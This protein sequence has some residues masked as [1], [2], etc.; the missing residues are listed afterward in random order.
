[1]QKIIVNNISINYVHIGHGKPLVLLHG[2]PLDH[3]IWD[4]L[5]P[6]LESDFELII[7]D[8]RGFGHSEVVKPPF[9]ISEMAADVT[10]LLNELGIDK[11]IIAGHSM[12]GYISLAFA[13]SNPDKLLGL[14]IISSQ[15][16]ADTQEK[17]KSRYLEIEQINER[18]VE[19]LAKAMPDKLSAS[20][21]L[22]EY[23]G[24]IISDQPAVGVAGALG[25]IAERP[26]Q[27][28]LLGTFNKPFLILHGS[29]DALIPVQRS[30]DLNHVTPKSSLVIL[31][32]TG[33][34]PML[35]KP[36][37]TAGALRL[38]K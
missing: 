31:P 33:H 8:L 17:K 9:S 25:A 22:T 26:D 19:I 5:V 2:F 11:A 21:R 28:F 36:D 12:G 37:D 23:L 27:S 30:I 35:E 1:M 18:G 20:P 3:R 14:G 6:L 10:G 32:D 16:L 38:L 7:P 4:D 15:V 29:E 34:M 13:R 24:K